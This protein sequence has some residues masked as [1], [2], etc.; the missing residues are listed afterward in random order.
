MAKKRW[1]Q[2][3]TDEK[4]GAI[5]DDLRKIM[6]ILGGQANRISDLEKAIKR[7]EKKLNALTGT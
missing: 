2:L 3:T 5:R 6:G 4:I 1:D 7:I